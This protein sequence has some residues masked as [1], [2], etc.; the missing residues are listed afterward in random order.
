MQPIKKLNHYAIPKSCNGGGGSCPLQNV[1][2]SG[3]MPKAWETRYTEIAVDD[4]N[5]IRDDETGLYTPQGACTDGTYIY[6]A[7]VNEDELPTRLQKISIDTGEVEREVT[8]TAYGHANDMCYAKGF[9]YIAHSSSTSIVYKVDAATLEYVDTFNVASTIWGIDYDP[10]QDVFIVGNVG[11]AYFSVYY[12]DFTFMYRIKPQNAFTGLVRQGIH[13]DANYIYVALDNAYGAVLGNEQGSRVMVYT[14]NGMFI[15]SIYIPIA[16]IEWVFENGG[17]L[18]FGT[19]EGRDTDN[20]KHGKIYGVP[21]DL[22]PEQ[23]VLTGRP[24]DVSGGLNNLQRLPEGTP[25]RL[26]TGSARTGDIVLKT[27]PHNITIDENAPFRYLRFRFAAANQQVFDWYPTN[28]GVVCLREVD[29][30]A[31]ATDSNIRIR[32]MRLTFDKANQTFKID[33][34]FAE[35][36]L[37]DVSENKIIITKLTDPVADNLIEVTQIWGIV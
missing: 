29:I 1:D 24:T 15:K 27:K 32:E 25:V 20:I 10:V 13:C 3:L 30:T 9:L 37:N 18:Y 4:V 33:S 8:T 14:W 21:F 5:L 26:W 7:L 35:Q 31:A 2:L 23:T 17:K 6:R 12:P 22:Y 16:E 11:S 34:S 19:Y 28:N 36:I